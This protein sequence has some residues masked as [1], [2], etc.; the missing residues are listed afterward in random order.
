MAVSRLLLQRGYRVT[1][2][3]VNPKGALRPDCQINKERLQ[4][5]PNAEL[6][7]LGSDFEPP[8]IPPGSV[9]VDGLFGTGLNKPLTGIYATLVAHINAATT[10]V[11]AIDMPSG[12][13]C[14]SNLNN[15]PSHI[16]QADFT[17]TFQLPKLS[18]LID[19]NYK[20]VSRLQI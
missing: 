4:A 6:L 15:N 16:I 20:C 10:T 14:E 12:L 19:D 5:I 3:L 13:M 9:V 11:V 1:T 17:L 2:Y 18:L 8:V 7:E